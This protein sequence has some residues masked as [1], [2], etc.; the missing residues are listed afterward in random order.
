MENLSN[1]GVINWIRS[2][3]SDEEIFGFFQGVVRF[4]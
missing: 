1:V 2:V 4:L 3:I